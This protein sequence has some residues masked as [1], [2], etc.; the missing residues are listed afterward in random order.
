[1]NIDTILKDRILDLQNATAFLIHLQSTKKRKAAIPLRSSS[2][3]QGTEIHTPPRRLVQN[4]NFIYGEIYLVEPYN[5]LSAEDVH[6]QNIDADK[7]FIY[8]TCQI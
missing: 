2:K 4:I 1:M 3:K 8:R 7:L 5:I 6:N